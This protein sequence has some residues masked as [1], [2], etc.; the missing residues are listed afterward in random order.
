MANILF[1]FCFVSYDLLTQS[2]LSMFCSPQKMPGK[3]SL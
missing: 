2:I 1:R 3:L